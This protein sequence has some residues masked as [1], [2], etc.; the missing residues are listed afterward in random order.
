MSVSSERRPCEESPRAPFAMECGMSYVQVRRVHLGQTKRYLDISELRERSSHQL[1]SSPSSI[2]GRLQ[3]RAFLRIAQTSTCPLWALVLLIVTSVIHTRATL[4]RTPPIAT[5]ATF[6]QR[7]TYPRTNRHISPWLPGR[8]QHHCCCHQP[9]LCPH[10]LSTRS[11][12]QSHH[13]ASRSSTLQQS[14][15]V[16]SLRKRKA[17]KLC[18]GLFAQWQ[19]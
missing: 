9:N 11:T 14:S 18:Y 15:K 8:I 6:P 19:I 2:T 13:K 1:Q 4:H 7:H 16:E 12:K 17:S 3:W 10:P 5:S